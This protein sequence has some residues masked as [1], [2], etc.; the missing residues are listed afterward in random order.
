MSVCIW[1]SQARASKRKEDMREKKEQKFKICYSNDRR[2][3]SGEAEAEVKL[4]IFDNT[5]LVRNHDD[6]KCEK[7]ESEDKKPASR[8]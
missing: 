3:I 2:S 1:F 5:F 7:S 8:W 4:T 6:C